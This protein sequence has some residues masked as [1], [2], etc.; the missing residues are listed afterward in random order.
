MSRFNS[1][2][3]IA[4]LLVSQSFFSLPHWHAGTSIAEPDGHAYHPHIHLRG[5]DHHHHHGSP[6]GIP[7]S[8]LSHPAP[9]H[10]SDA[11][12]FVDVHLLI[13]SECVKIAEPELSAMAIVVDETAIIMLSC[14]P[15]QFSDRF[16]LRTVPRPKCALFLQHRSIRC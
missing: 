10:D 5:S 3:L 11:L 2:I 4:I 8:S 13:N 6:A 12:Y 7:P 16:V 9:A 1:V 15:S 14:L